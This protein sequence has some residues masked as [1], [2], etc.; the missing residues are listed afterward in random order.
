V[1]PLGNPS[2]FALE[3]TV[4][5]AYHGRSFDDL[6]PALPGADYGHPTEVMK[7]MLIMRHLAPIY[8]GRTPLAPLPTDGLL[9]DPV[10]EILVTGHAHTFGAD[11]YRGV[12]LLNASTWQAETEYQRMRNITP[13]P[14]RAAVV[15]LA[16]L[17][18][19]AYDFSRPDRPRAAA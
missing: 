2:T 8:G 19:K 4:V 1:R 9:I 3:G 18:L 7:R 15:R 17:S 10:P 16:D 12:L 6:I 5:A 14:A 13:I 11:R